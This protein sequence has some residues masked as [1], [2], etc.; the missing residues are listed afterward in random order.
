MRHSMGVFC[1]CAALVAVCGS[2]L[3]AQ[4]VNRFDLLIVGGAVLD[5]TGATA[6]RVDVGIRGDRI[7]AMAA[8]LP[9]TNAA[10]VI[11]AAGRTVAPG[12][13]DLHAH[14]EP[15]LQ[16]PL[17]ESAMRQ[18]VTFALGGPD[19]GSPL[20]VGAMADVVIFDATT[21]KD[22]RTFTEPHQY[23]E[24]VDM[25]L[26]NGVVAVDRGLPTGARAGRVV[27]RPVVR[28]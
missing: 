26:V 5:G 3:S 9:R 14:L 19:G 18:G 8:S 17:L 24:G 1:W 4:P 22:R 7:V 25:V 20:R 13:M 23:P 12:F 11:D 6:Q 2:S 28:R 27:L 16:L 10:R 15:L 21:I